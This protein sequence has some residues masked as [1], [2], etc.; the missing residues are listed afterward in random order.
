MKTNWKELIMNSTGKL[1]GSG[2]IGLITGI[3]SLLGFISGNVLVFG[4]NKDGLEVMTISAYFMTIAG[5]LMGI[6]RFTVPQLTK[7]DQP[8]K[9]FNT[10][11]HLD[12]PTI[13][14]T[15]KKYEAS[16]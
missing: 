4:G 13:K 12:E 1:S 8:Q 3:V 9:D 7:Y 15:N 10:S 11:P 14:E 6:R 16:L 2:F 5:T